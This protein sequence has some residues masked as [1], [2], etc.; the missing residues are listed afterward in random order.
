MSGL[1]TSQ[2]RANSLRLGAWGPGR[3]LVTN[4]PPGYPISGPMSGL[5]DA[6]LW[7]Q[8]FYPLNPKF[9]IFPVTYRPA[10]GTRR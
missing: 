2:Y 10:L 8:W 9:Y 5:L 1:V 6:T 3:P 4:A 7:A